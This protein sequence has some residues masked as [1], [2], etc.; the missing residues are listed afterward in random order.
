M[1]GWHHRFDGKEYEQAL[2]AG[3]GQR[4]LLCCSSWDGKESDT[5]EQLV[6]LNSKADQKP[7]CVLQV[8]PLSAS[9]QEELFCSFHWET[10]VIFRCLYLGT[11]RTSVCLN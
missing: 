7:E 1:I 4:S 2:G 6:E 10:T 3:N 11:C 8:P 5:T 9:P